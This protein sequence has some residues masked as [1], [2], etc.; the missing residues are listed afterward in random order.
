M[1]GTLGQ[2]GLINRITNVMRA[3][4]I[5]L[6]QNQKYRKN[7]TIVTFCGVIDNQDELSKALNEVGVEINFESPA[8]LVHDLVEYI[9]ATQLKRTKKAIQM[10][11]EI[12]EGQYSFVYE[13]N[14]WS[15]K[16]YCLNQGL[17]LYVGLSAADFI[18]SNEITSVLNYTERMISL[19]DGMMAE[20]FDDGTCQFTDGE[21][22][23]LNMEYRSVIKKEIIDPE[24]NIFNI[25]RTELNGVVPNVFASKDLLLNRLNLS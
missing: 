15:K 12:L 5:N 22:Q 23:R 9:K 24:N 16:H 20:I 21:S 17:N 11:K 6:R 25:L 7:E 4:K 14:E 19:E 18:V 1:G 8:H 13:T 10:V 2:M 3:T